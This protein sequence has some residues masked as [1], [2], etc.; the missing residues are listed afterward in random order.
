M[1][2]DVENIYEGMKETRGYDI[3]C[4][5]IPFYGKMSVGKTSIHT[6]ACISIHTLTHTETF[7]MLYS[8]MISAGLEL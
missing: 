2:I 4:N 6:Y 3:L 5:V 8:K 1:N 7:E